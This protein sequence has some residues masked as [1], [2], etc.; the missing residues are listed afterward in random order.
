LALAALGFLLIAAPDYQSYPMLQPL[1]GLGN[2]W[3]DQ[4]YVIGLAL[5]TIGMAWGPRAKSAAR[6]SLGR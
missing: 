4:K 1:G 5:M 2:A 3:L 6:D